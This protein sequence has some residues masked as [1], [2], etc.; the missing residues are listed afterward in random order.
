MGFS[1]TA[2]R[3]QIGEEFQREETGRTGNYLVAEQGR[4]E[5]PEFRHFGQIEIG[6]VEVAREQGSDQTDRDVRPARKRA[7]AQFVRVESKKRRSIKQ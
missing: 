4:G 2:V 5:F 3:Q 7:S 6:I 1:L